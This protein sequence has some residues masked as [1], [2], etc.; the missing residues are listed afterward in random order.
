M[1]PR[2]PRR[3]LSASSLRYIAFIVPLRPMWRNVMSPSEIVSMETPAKVD[4]LEQA[5]GVF[6][7]AAESVE[8][9]GEHDLDF[10]AQRRLH[11]R[12]EA[13]T[14]ECCARHRVIRVLLGDLP[15]FALR[16]LAADAEL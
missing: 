14:Q 3:V 15:P 8:R 2:S 6:L 11:H 16:V 7:I 13:R 5:G 10:L 9:F 1:R 4:A 12:L